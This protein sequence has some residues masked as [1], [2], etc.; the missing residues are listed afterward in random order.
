[1]R[2]FFWQCAKR[3]WWP[4]SGRLWLRCQAHRPLPIFFLLERQEIVGLHHVEKTG[5]PIDARGE[6]GICSLQI[7]A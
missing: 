3:Q 6:P 4:A 1:M 5:M 7:G 2:G